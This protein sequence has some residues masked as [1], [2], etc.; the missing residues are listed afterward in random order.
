MLTYSV[1]MT[2]I[3]AFGYFHRTSQRRE[4]PDLRF[5]FSE[6]PNKDDQFAL[7]EQKES[8]FANSLTLKL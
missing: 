1:G 7:A 3:L 5:F 4:E 6:L 2:Y 8:K